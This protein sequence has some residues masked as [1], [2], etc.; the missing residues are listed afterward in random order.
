MVRFC[1]SESVAQEPSETGRLPV[2]DAARTSQTIK[3]SLEA[4][5]ITGLAAGG[6]VAVRHELV[7]HVNH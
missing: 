7:K 3:A 4:L 1:E 2:P 6:R 5:L